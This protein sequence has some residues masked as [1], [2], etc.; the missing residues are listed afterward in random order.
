MNAPLW[1][2]SVEFWGSLWVLLLVNLRSKSRPLYN[3][4]L[5]ASIVILGSNELTLFTIGHLV[6][7]MLRRP[8][9]NRLIA[10]PLIWCVAATC[11]IGGVA[12]ATVAEFDN[13]PW[14]R[15]LPF[16]IF[17]YPSAGNL[18]PCL[19]LGA[20]LIFAGILFLP[21]AQTLL[22][23]RIPQVLGKLSFSI[24]LLHYPVMQA[25]APLLFFRLYPYLPAF[26]GLLSFAGGS[27]LTLAMA[28]VFERLIDA[29][30]VHLSRRVSIVPPWRQTAGA[31][32]E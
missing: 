32:A 31:L 7:C 14:M 2:I 23:R 21:A 28:I 11:I 9:Y 22:A 10:N 8:D 16:G 12:L 25:I 6:F 17:A 30:A 5:L 4:T 3:A 26:A 27:A 15:F 19:E 29:L 24:Y 18:S 20:I 13:S 1:T